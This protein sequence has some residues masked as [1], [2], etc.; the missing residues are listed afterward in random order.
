MGERQSIPESVELISADTA[1]IADDVD[2][3]VGESVKA[4]QSIAGDVAKTTKPIRLFL[5]VAGASVAVATAA[6]V[7][8]KIF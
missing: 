5:Y 3:F 1:D 7:I 4:V 8:R 6:Y 2:Q